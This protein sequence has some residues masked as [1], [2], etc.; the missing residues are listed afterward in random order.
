MQTVRFRNYVPLDEHL[1]ASLSVPKAVPLD[2]VSRAKQLTESAMHESEQAT[3][4][5]KPDWDLKRDIQDKLDIL[6][7]RTME[8]IARLSEC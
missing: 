6:D 8:A 3:A 4:V 7:K 5:R 2:I 1:S